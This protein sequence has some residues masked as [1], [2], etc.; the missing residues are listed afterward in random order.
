MPAQRV[1]VFIDGFNFYF[2]MMEADLGNARWL[3]W[4]SLAK[5]LNTAEDRTL[6]TT[7]YYTARVTRDP[8]GQRRQS[9]YIDAL[10]AHNR[11]NAFEIIEG[12]MQQEST[13][14]KHC[15][16]QFDRAVEKHTDVNIA[17]AMIAGAYRD[18]Y[19]VAM[20]VSGDADQVAAVQAVRAAGKSV[21]VVFPPARTSTHLKDVANTAYPLNA[22]FLDAC[23]LPPSLYGPN[24]FLLRRPDSW[25]APRT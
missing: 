18:E 20:L 12:R 9:T 17:A 15:S 1:D 6:G 13:K 19:D 11:G 3:D 24:D 7:R 2:G 4:V 23:Q 10:R 21:R 22:T 5:R 25:T 16:R 14:C 8:D